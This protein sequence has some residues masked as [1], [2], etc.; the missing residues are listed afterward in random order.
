MHRQYQA[1]AQQLGVEFVPSVTPGYNDRAVRRTCADKPALA[2]ST[3]ANA[4]LNEL[5][6][7]Y[8]NNSKLKMVHITSFNERHQDSEIEPSIVTGPTTADT[9]PTG[10]QCTQG[11]VYQGFGATY[12]DILRREIAA[13]KPH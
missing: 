8:A 5:A 11:L 6:L 3:S 13:F 12:L 10:A 1:V 2:R 7:P 4:F 9:S